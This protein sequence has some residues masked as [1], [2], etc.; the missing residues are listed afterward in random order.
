MIKITP[1]LFGYFIYLYYLCIVKQKQKDY[2][3][4]EQMY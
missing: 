4:Q 1:F 2:G 3:L